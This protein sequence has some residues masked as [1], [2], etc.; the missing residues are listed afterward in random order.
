MPPVDT[1]CIE[2]IVN[3]LAQD[4]G[5]DPVQEP[6]RCHSDATDLVLVQGL[7]IQTV[8]VSE[9]SQAE[10]E[11]LYVIKHVHI[12]LGAVKS[13]SGDIPEDCPRARPDPQMQGA[14]L[15]A[16]RS[17]RRSCLIGRLDSR[18]EGRPARIS[19]QPRSLHGQGRVGPPEPHPSD[20]VG[21]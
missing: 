17:R 4:R 19:V 12:R 13:D 6:D 3:L 10:Y 2:E 20:W 7:D 15:R 16:S 9:E 1:E 18:C 14:G 8:S 5:A 21:S 11:A